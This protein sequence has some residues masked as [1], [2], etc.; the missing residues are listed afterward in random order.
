MSLHGPR[1]S[2]YPKSFVEGTVHCL[3]I[4]SKRTSSDFYGKRTNF[5]FDKAENTETVYKY[6]YLFQSDP[7][8]VFRRSSLPSGDSMVLTQITLAL[9]S[10]LQTLAYHQQT[11]DRRFSADDSVLFSFVYVAAL[12][13]QQ[14]TRQFSA[15]A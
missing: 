11:H 10:L 14:Q 6:V 2:Y 7:R 4:A 12:A 15:D 8:V 9:S 3:S 1:R 5:S 13:C